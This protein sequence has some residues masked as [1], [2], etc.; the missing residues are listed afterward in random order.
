[1]QNR[2]VDW[3]NYLDDL[4][5]AEIPD[6]A[7][8]AFEKMGALLKELCVEESKSK[9]CGPCTRMI[10]LGIIVSLSKMTL[11]LDSNCVWKNQS[12]KPVGLAPE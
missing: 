4:G 7:W 9:A 11:E 5:G 12:L 10:F 1:M 2:N 3:E 6:L 8:E